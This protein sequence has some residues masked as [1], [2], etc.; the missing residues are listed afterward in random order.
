MR[1][2]KIR[3]RSIIKKIL[4]ERRK[5]QLSQKANGGHLGVHCTRKMVEYIIDK[6]KPSQMKLTEYDT[7]RKGT[8]LHR[9]EPLD[10]VS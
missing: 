9:S 8:Q 3:Q 5:E 7:S 10:Q 6:R 2:V 4:P 1:T